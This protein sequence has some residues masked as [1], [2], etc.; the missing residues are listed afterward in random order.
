M[1]AGFDGIFMQI[2]YIPEIEN[3][4]RD[5][6]TVAVVS[7]IFP[8]FLRKMNSLRSPMNFHHAF[9]SKWQSVSSRENIMGF[10]MYFH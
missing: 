3:A 10:T 5:K 9:T 2:Q 4:Q 6:V 1:L 8:R 7:V